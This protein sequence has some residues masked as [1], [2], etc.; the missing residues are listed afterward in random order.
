MKGIISYY[1]FKIILVNVKLSKNVYA[2]INNMFMYNV[3]SR[4]L[5]WD[6]FHFRIITLNVNFASIVPSKIPSSKNLPQ[7]FTYY[8]HVPV[9]DKKV[10]ITGEKS[11]LPREM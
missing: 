6:P 1:H 3:Q 7:R 4:V 9:L 8:E 10:T 11:K 5:F 2:R